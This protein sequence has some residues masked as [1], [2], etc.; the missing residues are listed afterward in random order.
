MINGARSPIAARVPPRSGAAWTRSAT[1]VPD[2]DRARFDDLVVGGPRR[3]RRSTTTTPSSC[4][5]CRSGSS[6]AP[7]SRS[8]VAWR[9][10]V[11]SHDEADAFEAL[12]RRAAA[13]SSPGAGPPAAVLAARRAERLAARSAHAAGRGGRPGAGRPS[14]SI[15]RPRTRRLGAHVRRVVG[16][17]AAARGPGRAAATVGSR[18]RA[19]PGA[20]R[21]RSRRRAQC[22]SS[23]ATSW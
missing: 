8:A 23:P 16:G 22:G 5:R 7:C 13:R 4:S 6:A 10:A 19:R 9:R 15:C 17:R 11:A 3:L 21:A 18:G 20:R 1:S 12:G 14:R 2:A